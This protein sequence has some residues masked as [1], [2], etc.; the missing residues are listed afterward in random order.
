MLGVTEDDPPRYLQGLERAADLFALL[1]AGQRAHPHGLIGG[2]ADHHPAQALP[3]RFRDRVEL[4]GRHEGASDRRALLPGFDGHLRD[5]LLDVPVERGGAGGGVGAE[6]RHVQRVG[7]G[8][9]P[10]RPRDHVRMRPEPLGGA[11]RAGE[12]Q[13]VLLLQVIEE[14]PG[15]AADEL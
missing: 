2:V 11:G 6:N 3:H 14:V 10:H 4:P 7:L 15:A 12:A 9:E 5:Q 8:V 1:Q 13:Q